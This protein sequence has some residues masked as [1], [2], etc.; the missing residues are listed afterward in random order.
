MARAVSMGATGN[1]DIDGLLSGVRWSGTVTYS[2]PDSRNDYPSG[3]GS[4]EPHTGFSQIA[5][6]TQN[7]VNAVMASLEALT[8]ITINFAGTNGADIQIAKSSAANPT[9]YAYYP[10]NYAEGGDVWF[11][12]AYDYSHPKVGDYYYQTVLHELGHSFGLKH[13]QETGGPA[14]VALPANHDALEYSV[15]TYRSYEGASTTGG[16]TNEQY[17]YPQTYMMDDIA[18]FQAMYGANFNT[19]S[20]DTVYSWSPT[21]GQ[22][23]IDGVA[24]TAPGANRIFSTIWDGGGNDTYDFSAYSN[25]LKI[26][27]TPGSYSNSSNVQLAYLG[28]GHYAHGNVYNAY[29]YNSDARS[30]IENAIGGS[31]NDTLIGNAANNHLD[32]G[33]GADVMKGGLGNDT[34]VV[35]NSRD[36]VNEV[37]GSG[38]DTIES[39][40]SWNLAST[41][42]RGAVEDLTLTGSARINGFG[43]AL[44][45]VITGNSNNNVLNG[46]AGAD[47]LIGG[48][49]V[50]TVSYAGDT[51][52][53][54]ADLMRAG[55]QSGG[56]A[57]GDVLSGIRSLIG[58]SGNDVLTGDGQNNRLSGG[59]G[60]DTL[61]GGGHNDLLTGGIGA[62]TFVFAASF[63]KDK[64]LDF[65]A[66]TTA[67]HDLVQFDTVVFADYS[68]VMN[69][70]ATVGGDVVITADA[71]D[72]LTLHSVTLA[73]LVNDDFKFV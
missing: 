19:H 38:T 44:D 4:G 41:H 71:H 56:Y 2:F 72:A 69:H 68:D 34:Y 24:Q 35:D 46:R 61:N 11:G 18:A 57:Q 15:M 62:D 52:G 22:M 28:N 54:N 63:G 32:G 5:A 7:A 67:D 17:G 31:G 36:T 3:Y 20:G 49:G 8:N 21:T 70:A 25:S 73:S 9:S 47:H 50:D 12:T 30:Y 55:A 1:Q 42:V 13:G 59:A 65:A 6:G 66:G 60:N 51:A 58:G 45:N 64:I 29:L 14:N 48:G 43:N 33:A 23:S 37:G 16:Y 10:G 40:I 39:S 26:D 27:L 53:V